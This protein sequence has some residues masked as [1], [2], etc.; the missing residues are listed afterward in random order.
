MEEQIMIHTL[1]T[2][3]GEDNHRRSCSVTGCSASVAIERWPGG[4]Y[5]SGGFFRVV[6]PR[7][8][9]TRMS[10]DICPDC[11]AA[12]KLPPKAENPQPFPLQHA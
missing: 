1:R 3:S 10:Y 12:G 8:K 2:E 11:V 7:I 4:S 5:T 9:N 6:G